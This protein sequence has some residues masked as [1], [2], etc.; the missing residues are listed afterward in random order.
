MACDNCFRKS[1]NL[2]EHNGQNTYQNNELESKAGLLENVQ[3]F[4][5][6]VDIVMPV[7]AKNLPGFLG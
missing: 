6:V 7:I 5:R 3:G 2:V 1:L 4:K